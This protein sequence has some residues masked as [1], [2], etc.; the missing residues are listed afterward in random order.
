MNTSRQVERPF[1]CMRNPVLWGLHK[2][3]TTVSETTCKNPVLPDKLWQKEMKLFACGTCLKPNSRGAPLPAERAHLCRAAPAQ[4]S[5]LLP[6]ILA[7]EEFFETRLTF[8]RP[9]QLQSM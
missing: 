1:T 8:D 4:G 3:K 9:L 7:P 6:H 2:L 5:V